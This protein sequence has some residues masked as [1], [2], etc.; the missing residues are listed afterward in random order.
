MSC[1]A[2]FRN[3]QVPRLNFWKLASFCGCA[4]AIATLS[5]ATKATPKIQLDAQTQQAMREAI[6]DEYQARALYRAIIDKLGAIRPFS[7]I[8]RAEERHISLWKAIFK[9]YG[10]AIPT[11]SFAGKLQVPSTLQAACQAG[12]DAEIANIALYDRFLSF[13]QQP[14]LRST[15]QQLRQ[16]SLNNHLP[17]FQRCA[18]R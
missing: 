6:E 17:A 7:N 16:V 2:G 14:D 11:D 13:V 3:G 1:Q 10:L 15:F 9:Q 18:S 12:V 5:T 4:V 8:V